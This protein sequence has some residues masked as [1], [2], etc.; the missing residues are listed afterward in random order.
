[1]NSN[2]NELQKKERCSSYPASNPQ[3]NKISQS[4][5]NQ[6]CHT[7]PQKQPLTPL[8]PQRQTTA[9]MHDPTNSSLKVNKN[10]TH[11]QTKNKQVNT[12]QN[13]SF[14]TQFPHAE[15]LQKIEILCSPPGVSLKNIWKL[16]TSRNPFLTR[17]LGRKVLIPSSVMAIKLVDKY[18]HYPKIIVLITVQN[19]SVI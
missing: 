1:M 9:L 8:S 16:S 7:N 4:C 18:M 2:N 11:T 6:N 13:T 19:N 14:S 5:P 17:K 12:V 10:Q 3:E 15:I